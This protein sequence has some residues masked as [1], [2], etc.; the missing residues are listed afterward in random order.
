MK[1]SVL[2]IVGTLVVAIAIGSLWH[3]GDRW[4]FE[5]K[6]SDSMNMAEIW[7]Y[8]DSEFGFTAKYPSFFH[9]DSIAKGYASFGFH[10]KTDVVVEYFTIENN[11]S[12]PF[13]T[14]MEKLAATI[15]ATDVKPADSSFTASGA[16][17]VNGT[18]VEGY[19]FHS[20]YVYKKRMWFVCRLV[21]AERYKPY[22]KR[23]FEIVD[24]WTVW[25]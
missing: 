20:K 4:T 9:A 8:Q 13:N 11:D 6:L 23:M 24:N 15:F 21:Y 2:F 5:E 19:S 12:L 16:L 7:K 22:M 25:E 18:A 1:K 3:S 14:G 17:H 10:D